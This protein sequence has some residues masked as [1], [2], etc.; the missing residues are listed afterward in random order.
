MNCD[1][2]KHWELDLENSF[3]C[4]PCAEMIQRLLIVQNRMDSCDRHK[5]ALAVAQSAAISSRWTQWQ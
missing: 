2:C 1:L 5:S 4:E 3:L